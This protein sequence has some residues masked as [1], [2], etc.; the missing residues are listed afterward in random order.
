MTQAEPLFIDDL[1]TWT[2]SRRWVRVHPSTGEYVT[3]Y[4]RLGETR[5][6]VLHREIPEKQHHFL[7]WTKTDKESNPAPIKTR[8]SAFHLPAGR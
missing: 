1:L 4:L 2:G 8:L 7:W 6:L 3:N 5:Y